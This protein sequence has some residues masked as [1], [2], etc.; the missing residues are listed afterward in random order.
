MAPPRASRATSL[1]LGY[2]K[3]SSVN[4]IP[5][6]SAE[7]KAV[8]TISPTRRTS[9]TGN[10]RGKVDRKILRDRE[11]QGKNPDGY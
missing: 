5:A 7:R 6:P 8:K 9:V 10:D 4:F 3:Q 11:A 1:S 2:W